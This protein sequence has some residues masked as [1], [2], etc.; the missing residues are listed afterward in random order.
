MMKRKVWRVLPAAAWMM[1][2]CG[3][4][5]AAQAAGPRGFR[6]LELGMELEQVKARLAADALFG[7]RGDPDVSLLPSPQ[8]TLIEC[9][10]ASWVRR[11]FFQFYEGRLLSI[12]LVL[13]DRRLDYYTLFET[14]SQKYGGPARLDPAEAVWEFPGVRLSLERPLSV[15]YLDSGRFDE[16]RKQGQAVEALSAALRRAAAAALALAALLLSACTRALPIIPVRIG[17]VEFRVEVARSEEEKARGL[18]HRRSLGERSGMIFVYEADE[19]LSF[20]MK[21]TKLPLTL[22]FLSRDG[23]ILQIE[24]LKPLS[25]KPMTSAR[26]ARYALELPAGSLRRLGV[27]PGDRVE[28]PADFP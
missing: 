13:D 26:A 10:G 1:L 11:T 8:Q 28:L 21:N 17:G 4:L 7:Y 23:E 22:A 6:G 15:K 5:A 18:M 2:A 3:A 24:E 12:I 14:L 19:R 9:A 25:L 20:W 27:V 16:L